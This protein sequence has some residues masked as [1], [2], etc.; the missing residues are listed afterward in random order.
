M[1]KTDIAAIKKAAAEQYDGDLD[2]AIAAHLMGDAVI[3]RSG[4]AIPAGADTDKIKK[5]RRQINAAD[6][7]APLG[8]QGGKG[9]T[10]PA[11]TAETPVASGTTKPL[12]RQNKTE[13]LATAAA[14]GITVDPNATHKAIYGAIVEARGS[15]K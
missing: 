9:K 6:K 5:L 7:P 15:K 2:L 10:K 3:M 8:L 13:L 12:S 14:E 4:N 11:A 1:T